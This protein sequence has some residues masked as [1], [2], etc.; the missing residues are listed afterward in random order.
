MEKDSIKQ[1]IYYITFTYTSLTPF[2]AKFYFNAYHAYENGEKKK[3][4]F[5]S[6]DPFLNLTCS[7]Y[8]EAG[9][10]IRYLND[11][12]FIDIDYFNQ[13]KKYDR[14]YY[15]I[16]LEFTA[17]EDIPEKECKLA[18]MCKITRDTSGE[19]IKY[20]IKAEQQKLRVKNF[21]FEMHDVY[22]FSTDVDK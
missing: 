19:M 12:I 15:D 21:W 6:Y 22:G 2:K 14:E 9:T 13:N 11:S 16:I 18:T 5:I 10:N 1:N 17:N 4:S 20:K 8:C 3:D 7:S